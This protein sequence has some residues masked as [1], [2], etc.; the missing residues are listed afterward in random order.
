MASALDSLRE[1]P[2]ATKV[3]DVKK[4]I[5][6]MTN[7]A[8]RGSIE[9]R[10]LGV[11]KRLGSDIRKSIEDVSPPEYAKANA[12]QTRLID[13]KSRIHEKFGDDLSK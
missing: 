2:T 4:L 10:V 3:N 11:V 9:G 6:S 5:Q 13:L 1:A 7:T 8:D 12:E